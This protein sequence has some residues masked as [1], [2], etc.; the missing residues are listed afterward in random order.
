MIELVHFSKS[1][2]TL[3]G[4]TAEAAKDI[5]FTVRRNSVA[6]L[7]GPNGAGKTTVLKAVC[8]I[9]YPTSGSI[10]VYDRSGAKFDAVR[11]AGQSKRLIG[12]VSE[13]PHL[14]KNFTVAEYLNMTAGLWNMTDNSYFEKTV[15]NFKLENVLSK[16]IAALSKGYRQRVN[17]AGALIHN[18]EILVLDE[19]TSGLD[20]SQIVETRNIIKSFSKDK[21]ILLS[22]HNMREAENLCDTVA[23]I[24]GGKLLAEGTADSVKKTAGADSL[25]DAYTYFVNS[26]VE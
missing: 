22:T 25:E 24:S 2:R 4:K 3:F 18:P 6:G 10:F 23:I 13:I 21:T 16:K 1:Y 19:P 9:H 17:F 8:S 11:D 5:S 12:Y 7:L 14:Y 26:Q 15:R 20:P